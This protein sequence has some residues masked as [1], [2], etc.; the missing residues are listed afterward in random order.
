MMCGKSLNFRSLFKKQN[1]RPSPVKV[2]DGC[3]N[4]D[5]ARQTYDRKIEILNC[6][7]YRRSPSLSNND[8]TGDD[9]NIDKSGPPIN[10]DMLNDKIKELRDVVEENPNHYPDIHVHMGESVDDFTKARYE[11]CN[12]NPYDRN[13][14]TGW[15]H[16]DTEEAFK[17]SCE[18]IA[19]K[20]NAKPLLVEHTIWLMHVYY[21]DG[22]CN[23]MD[24]KSF[25]EAH[26]L[27]G[28]RDKETFRL[29]NNSYGFWF[30]YDIGE[31]AKR[32]E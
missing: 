32:L 2:K 18:I 11:C 10:I 23:E 22:E 3:E 7:S 26:K 17:H 12:R 13:T 29:L 9:S 16:N 25:D 24:I 4:D 31:I 5:I 14:L 1:K 28:L 6:I 30:H 27:Y 15:L 21:M 20:Y 8:I 19:N